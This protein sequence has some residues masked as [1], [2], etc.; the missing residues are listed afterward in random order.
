MPKAVAPMRML[1]DNAFLNANGTVSHRLAVAGTTGTNIAIGTLSM[2]SAAVAI[3]DAVAIG[4]STLNSSGTGANGSIAI[5][6]LALSSIMDTLGTV[7]IGFEAGRALSTGS[8]NTMVGY[9]TGKALTTQ[10]QNTLIGHQAGSALTQSFCTYVGALTGRNGTGSSNTAVGASAG[11]SMTTAAAN[12]YLGYNAGGGATSGGNNV[13]IGS[14]AGSSVTIGTSNITIGSSAGGMSSSSGNTIIGTSANTSAGTIQGTGLGYQS[15]AAGNYSTAIGA[16]T[17]ANGAGSVV[18][19]TDSTGAGASTGI[20]N[21]IRLGTTSHM[22]NIPGTLTVVTGPSSLREVTLTTTSTS[23]GAGN[24]NNN[25][26]LRLRNGTSAANT[27]AEIQFESSSVVDSVLI[28]AKIIDHATGRG[29]LWFHGRSTNGMNPRFRL[30]ETGGAVFYGDTGTAVATVSNLGALGA[31]TVSPAGLSGA[32]QVSRYA[33][34]TTAGAPTSGAFVAGDW[35]IDRAG[36]IRIC[37]VA[38]SPGT[39]VSA[40]GTGAA[41]TGWAVTAGYVADKTF[42]PESSTL[43]ECLRVLG[44]LIDAL[45]SYG[46]LA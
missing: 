41:D 2:T 19:G 24:V 25:V 7:G 37:T 39:W 46:I 17:T 44:T 26:P 15:Q 12:T 31:L 23:T 13:A 21:E 16:N 4:R 20:V 5:G 18:I 43:T 34:A 9:Q 42:N 35:V 36:T 27:W 6:G 32:T 30:P 29:E 45:K 8:Y 33:G 11:V 14:N 1:G 40:G 3:T 22:V 10:Q 38:G 28:G